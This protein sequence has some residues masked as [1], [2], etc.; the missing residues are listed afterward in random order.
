[1]FLTF[2]EHFYSKKVKCLI[3]LEIIIRV[4]CP[5]KIFL[6]WKGFLAK[7]SFPCHGKVCL[8]GKDY[9]ARERFSWQGKES[10]PCLGIRI[11]LP[12]NSFP[13]QDILPCQGQG[14]RQRMVS[15]TG[16]SFPGRERFTWLGKV[17]PAGKG[18]SF[19]EIFTWQEN[20]SLAGKF[21][22]SGK[23]FP[24]REKFLSQG[25]VP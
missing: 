3:G 17:Y 7:E 5:G 23:G 13:A 15:L 8:L 2:Y 24:A 6:P 14:S 22:L 11:S 4:C 19:G 16:E 21:S 18:F 12:E 25:K 20:V 9:P 10:F 1:M